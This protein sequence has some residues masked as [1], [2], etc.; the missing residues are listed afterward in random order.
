MGVASIALSFAAAFVVPDQR[1]FSGEL[2]IIPTE[3]WLNLTF[4]AVIG[5][6]SK[7]GITRALQLIEPT[8]VNV[9]LALEIVFGFAFQTA[10]MDQVP[11]SMALFGSALVFVSVVTISMERHAIKRFPKWLQNY[12]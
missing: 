4:V 8:A 11:T 12:L 9:L 10:F 5:L 3:D 1:I 6:V 7:Y 2:F